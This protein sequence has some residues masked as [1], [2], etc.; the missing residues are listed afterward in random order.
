MQGFV[1]DELTAAWTLI[2]PVVA[3][4][5][6]VHVSCLDQERESCRVV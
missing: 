6:A 2:S 4:E 3:C 5:Q 1:Y